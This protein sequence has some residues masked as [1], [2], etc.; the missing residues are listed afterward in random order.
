MAAVAAARTLLP[1]PLQKFH[2]TIVGVMLCSG[3]L[4]C[5]HTARPIEV[6]EPTRVEAQ[7]PATHNVPRVGVRW[8]NSFWRAV[9]QNDLKVAWILADTHD[10]RRLVDALETMLVGR[11]A[12]AE[13]Q[14]EPLLASND[15]LVRRAARITYG[16]LLSANG[17]WDRLASFADSLSDS[18]RSALRDDAGVERW[19]L[20][21]SKLRTSAQ[22]GR[23]EVVLPLTRSSTGAPVIPVQVNGVTRHF[24]L[25]TGSSISIVS[26][27]SA[28]V[29]RVAALVS[30]TLQLL[31]AVGRLPARPA[32]I[33]SLRVGS[34][35]VSQA[36]AMIVDAP[37]LTMR[38]GE[39]AQGIAVSEERIEGV[40]GFDVIRRLDITIDDVR[41]TVTIRGPVLGD[42]TAARNLAWY[43][44]P[45]AT[46]VSDRGSVLH[47]ALDTGAEE[48][49]GT[50][51]MVTKTGAHWVPA[52][53]RHVRGFGGTVL[54]RGLVIP[55]VRLFLGRVPL[56]LKRVFLYDAQYP[57]IFV[58]DG[59]LGAD[60]GRGGSLRID[61]TNGRLEV[62]Q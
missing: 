9:A 10:E 51:S 33:N 26:T 8:Y 44:L 57:S 60:L 22:F 45:I 53:R 18:T 42:S 17:R 61:M 13:L 4:G 21:F 43:G 31:T 30:D 46:V 27:Q 2:A 14:V 56:L 5:I 24:W 12:G 39:P 19:A 34:L 50:L 49:F 35:E 3:A 23:M 47:L 15:S 11:I 32:V 59:T 29:C 55:S 20:P 48:T 25:D 62:G 54:E 38:S 36:P 52:E 1:D 41:Q 16:A 28:A 40:I 37:L 6:T 58:I 7:R